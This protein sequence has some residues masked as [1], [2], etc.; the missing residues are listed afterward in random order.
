V[1]GDTHRPLRVGARPFEDALRPVRNIYLPAT[2]RKTYFLPGYHARLSIEAFVKKTILIAAILLLP[3]CSVTAV[4]RPDGGIGKAP[5][6]VADI[7][8]VMEAF[9][10]AV[11]THDGKG[12]SELFLD[13]GSTWVTVLTDKAFTAA[14]A[15]SASTQKVHVSSYQD[16]AAFVSSTTS[17]LDPHHADVRIT[18]DGAVA[19][20]YFHFAFVIN[21]KVENRGDETWQL[22]KTVDGWRIVAITY[23]SDP[24]A[25]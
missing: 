23:S 10:H 13:H 22:V 24:G 14:R 21:G 15:K 8:R 12:V 20:V 18:S 3:G 11:A 25:A 2:L 19:S 6:D 5:R 17:D 9:H 1:V 4:D 16:F 7:Q